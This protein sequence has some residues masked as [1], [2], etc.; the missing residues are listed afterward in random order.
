MPIVLSG[1]DELKRA[2][3]QFAP[4]LR[5]EMDSTIKAELKLVTDEA[6]RRVPGNAPGG[7]YNWDDK[8]V[9]PI[10]RTHRE[11]AFPKYN[12]I[13]VRKGLTYRMGTSRANKYG[14]AS[15]YS[16][17][18]ASAVGAIIETS[19][20][21]NPQGRPQAGRRHSKSTQ[22]FGGSNNRFAGVQFV[23]AMN[24]IGPIKAYDQQPRSR[25]R[26]LYAA[27]AE[28]SG[29]TLDAVIKAIELAAR[30]LDQRAKPTGMK[31]VA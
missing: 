20:R 16:L 14:F 19:G 31:K 28:R 25:G 26:L 6:K 24:G 13:H 7:L 29:K 17:L 10:S 27:Y 21:L 4:D 3:K 1:V 5:K 23:N 15:L 2:L 30:K 12:S 18:N 11:R 9:E 22:E 8:G